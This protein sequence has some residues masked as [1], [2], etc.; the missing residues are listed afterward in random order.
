MCPKGWPASA[1]GISKRLICWHR[2]GECALG[3]ESS[4]VA[5]HPLGRLDRKVDSVKRMDDE[6]GMNHGSLLVCE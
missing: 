3:S 6:L 1:C 5:F 4:T 2:I